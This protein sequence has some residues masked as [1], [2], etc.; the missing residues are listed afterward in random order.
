MRKK[1]LILYFV[2]LGTFV[3][4][5]CS[6]GMLNNN[7]FSSSAPAPRENNPSSD[8]GN[9]GF[10]QRNP[11][12]VWAEVQQIPLDKLETNQNNPDQTAAGWLKLA[13][14]SKR[15]STDTVQLTQQL[16]GW[17]A[18][19]P[20]HP[21]NQE[22]PN[23]GT[24]SS[25]GATQPPKNIALL[26]PL[27]GKLS[28]LGNAV[29]NGFVGSYYQS[30]SKT[31]YAQ[32]IS[33]YDTSNGQSVTSLYQQAVAKGADMVVGPLTKEDVQ[34]LMSSGSFTV[35]TLALNYTDQW[36]SLPSNF[37]E[38]GL[39]PLD[40]AKQVADKAW[41]T[42]HTSAIIIAPETDWGRRAVKSLTDRWTADGGKVTDTYLFSPKANLTK[43]IA[44]LLH[45]DTKED[46]AKTHDLQDR[47]SLEQ[48]RRHDFDVIFLLAPPQS[49]RQIVPLL[50]FYYVDKTAIF[51]T[52]V[53]YAGT[54]QPQKDNDLNGVTFLD[55]P[56]ILGGG[57]GAGAPDANRLF[58]VGQ[59]AYLISR[60][61]NRF[62][63][64]ANFPL[65]GT[66]GAL[67]LT[68]Q[69]QFYRRLAWAQIHDGHP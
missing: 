32:A 68:P 33:F 66:T 54:P 31:S 5:S 48:Q 51:A 3:L 8:V 39:S 15:Y 29:R 21:G 59:D 60:N 45:I 46:T 44:Q 16:T 14:I 58:A 24:L 10:W 62:T 13:I 28:P 67:T 56:W 23:D 25:L 52:S 34:Q 43:D 9:P 37:Y 55:S 41:Q 49:A 6:S 18:Q 17:R 20:N 50:R 12:A 42:G 11:D 7:F 2:L 1:T 22:F 47:A 40:E 53:V 27:Q 57:K 65:Y 19:Y 38:F 63:T 61:I 64:L 26:L 36:G 30:L 35:P 4:T 69:K